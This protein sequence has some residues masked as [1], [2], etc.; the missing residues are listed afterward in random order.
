MLLPGFYP[1]GPAI[2]PNPE[3]QADQFQYLDAYRFLFFRNFSLFCSEK[4]KPQIIDKKIREERPNYRINGLADQGERFGLRE[5]LALVPVEV[6]GAIFYLVPVAVV[7]YL[8]GG[9]V[10]GFYGGRFRFCRHPRFSHSA[11]LASS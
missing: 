2:L 10:V 5:R 1:G 3:F 4:V 8:A 9:L 11:P 6:V 7:A